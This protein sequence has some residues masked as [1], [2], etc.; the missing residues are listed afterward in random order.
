MERYAE[1]FWQIEREAHPSEKAVE[2][3]VVVGDF[4]RAASLS[5]FSVPLRLP[6]WLLGF[7][8]LS[9]LRLFAA[10][11]FW[12]WLR[13]AGFSRSIQSASVI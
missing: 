12:S 5:F 8:A 2:V 1:G 10:I 13:F 11:L 9:L 6:F 3:L 4:G 7:A